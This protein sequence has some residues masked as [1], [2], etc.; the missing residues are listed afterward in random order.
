MSP[1]CQDLLFSAASGQVALQDDLHWEC[2]GASN[3][4]GSFVCGL[5]S[6]GNMPVSLGMHTMCR[7]TAGGAL[8]G[9]HCLC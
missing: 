4:L 9:H 1:D 2:T 7:C 3:E 5:G 8:L 6:V